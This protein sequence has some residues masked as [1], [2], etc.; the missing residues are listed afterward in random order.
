MSRKISRDELL[1]NLKDVAGKL[2][3]TPKKEDLRLAKGSKYGAA[4]YQREFGSISNAL[5]AADM[6]PHQRR[7]LS[8][9]EVLEDIQRVYKELGY[10]PKHREYIQM[11]G[12]Y[13]G[14]DPIKSRFGSW[15]NALMEAGI[16]IENVGKANKDFVLRELRKWHLNHNGDPDC[17]TYWTLR[18]AKANRKFPMSCATIRNAF[19]GFSWEE[20][21]KQIDARY[22]TNDMFKHRTTHIG[23]DGNAYKSK[24][25]LKAGDHLFQ[26]KKDGRIVDYRYE[27]RV[28][29]SRQWTCDFVID[30]QEGKSIWLEVDGLRSNRHVPYGPENDKICY[31]MDT[32]I[33]YHIL[34]YNNRSVKNFINSLLGEHFP[35]GPKGFDFSFKAEN[36]VFF[37]K[38]EIYRYHQ[39]HGR[40][41]VF[42]DLV[43]PFYEYL[44]TYINKHGW[45]YP[46][47]TETLEDVL[48]KLRNRDGKLMSADRIGS[49]FMKSHFSSFWHASSGKFQS[50]ISCTLKSSIMLPLL[51]YRFGISNSRPYQYVFDGEKVTFNELFDI[52]LKAVRRSLEVNRYTVS[53]FKPIVAK[54]IYQKFGFE[55]MRVWDPCGG[56]GGR[57]LGF[58]GT[59][60]DG[61]YI[62][63]EPNPD[64]YRELVKLGHMIGGNITVMPEA[65]EEAPIQKNIDMVFTCPPYRFREHYCDSVLQ[66]DVKYQTEEEWDEGFLTTLLNKSL[67]SLNKNGICVFIVDQAIRKSIVSLSQVMG[68]EIAQILPIRNQSTHL[69]PKPNSEFYVVLRPSCISK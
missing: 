23:K 58:C 9:K 43:L 35:I 25:E 39:S 4:A 48:M 51:K 15:T 37:T 24:L 41:A 40:E 10:T 66:S 45:L 14:Y 6:K 8:K 68:F 3:R 65:I 47:Q 52:S 33:K 22:E 64:T 18:K 27:V 62:A 63:N 31:Y 28:C 54:F 32:G 60:Q 29:D 67:K 42:S 1:K 59:F 16:P 57:M 12:V 38:E 2:N 26:L 50:P 34:S 21:M 7:G 20:I 49:S 55:G 44:L 61:T 13:V 53:L 46:E 19:K 11:G 5:L 30:T 17:L 36:F 56:F 69:N